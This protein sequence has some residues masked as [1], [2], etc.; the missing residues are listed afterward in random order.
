MIDI[1]QLHRLLSEQRKATLYKALILRHFPVS[2]TIVSSR[3]VTQLDTWSPE[4]WCNTPPAVRQ[5]VSQKTDAES[6]KELA[7]LLQPLLGSEIIANAVYQDLA[8]RCADDYFLRKLRNLVDEKKGDV[9]TIASHHLCRQLLVW[10]LDMDFK[11]IIRQEVEKL[12][13]QKSQLERWL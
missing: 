6:R 11:A 12:D 7:A 8:E 1:G 13:Q 4:F 3:E 10:L 2:Y 5:A 9:K